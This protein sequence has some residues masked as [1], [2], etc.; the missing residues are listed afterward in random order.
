MRHTDYRSLI[1]RGRRAG[2]GTGDLYRALAA[3]PPEGNDPVLSDQLDGNG[4][5]S[6]YDQ[7][8]HRVF[9]PVENLRRS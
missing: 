2:L 8:G 1:D 9:R 4:F 6:S 7:R 3:Q 5:V